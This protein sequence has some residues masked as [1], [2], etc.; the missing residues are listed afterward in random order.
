MTLYLQVQKLHYTQR[1]LKPAG[2]TSRAPRNLQNELAQHYAPSH[3][4]IQFKNRP[5]PSAVSEPP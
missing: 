4:Q 3:G 2:E 1:G 5:S